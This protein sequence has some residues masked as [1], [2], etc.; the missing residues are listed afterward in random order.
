MELR[1]GQ[2]T[3]AERS[4]RSGASDQPRRADR[5]RVRS[6]RSALVATLLLAACG[7]SPGPD[8]VRYAPASPPESSGSRSTGELQAERSP[9]DPHTGVRFA[10]GSAELQPAAR[11]YLRE[12][13][14]ELEALA[15]ARRVLIVGHAD[16]GEP[17]DELSLSRRRADA[18]RRYLIERGIAPD[19]L[20]AVGRGARGP[21]AAART[22][23]SGHASNR[24]VE[25]VVDEHSPPGARPG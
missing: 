15:E 14:H 4:P 20:I 7:S 11:R 3:T 22:R 9:G 12:A 5:T 10:L 21:V 13:A 23:P 2:P 18:V 8:A 16:A 19:R 24:R 1:V 17:G 25:I 6:P